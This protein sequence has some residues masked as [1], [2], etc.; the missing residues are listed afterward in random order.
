MNVLYNRII[1]KLTVTGA[2]VEHPLSDG[3][4]G[5]GAG[6]DGHAVEHVGRVLYRTHERR[7]FRYLRVVRLN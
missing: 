5:R 6:G 4:V 2:R 7:S 3:G 1:P